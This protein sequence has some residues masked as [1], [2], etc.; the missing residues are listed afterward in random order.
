M[1][2]ILIWYCIQLGDGTPCLQFFLTEEAAVHGQEENDKNYV[3]CLETFETSDIHKEACD[4]EA[5]YEAELKE[6]NI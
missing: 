1:V 6:N 4:N 3:N 2:G 5:T